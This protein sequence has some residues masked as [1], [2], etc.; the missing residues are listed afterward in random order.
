MELNISVFNT[1]PILE[2]KR[3]ILRSIET[4]DASQIQKMRSNGMVN[5]FIPRPSMEREEDAIALVAKTINAFNNKQAIGWAGVLKRNGQLTGTCGFNTIDHYNLRAEIGGELATEFWG[6]NIALEAVGAILDFG[7][8]TL[9]LHSVEAKVSPENRGA[10]H[11]L[12][13]F[14]FKKEAHF[15]DRILFN[16][17]FSDMAV[18]TL[19]KS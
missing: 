6:K 13:Y 10:I 14:G 5:R 16:G 11:L 3:L 15:K 1:F 19:I 4:E 18:Y 7:I 12:E 9:N 17:N 8:N 2:T